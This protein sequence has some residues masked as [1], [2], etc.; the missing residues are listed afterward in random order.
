MV[1]QN[2]KTLKKTQNVT[3][4]LCFFISWHPISSQY[5]LIHLRP[6]AES[7]RYRGASGRSAECSDYGTSWIPDLLMG[8]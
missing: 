5:N 8:S 2:N 1:H 4:C 7:G 6:P 3:V